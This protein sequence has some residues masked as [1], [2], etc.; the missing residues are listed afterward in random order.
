MTAMAQPRHQVSRAVAQLEATLDEVADASVWSMDPAETAHTLV[1][2]ERTEARLVE[3]KS[4]VAAH[5]DD[6]HVGQDVGAPSAAN[7]L[8]HETK[9]T[10]SAAHRTVRFGHDL[11]E[12][13]LTRG[14][15]ASG[16]VRAE[17]ARVIIRWVDKLPDTLDAR[18]RAKAE[19]HLLEQ[20]REHD[21]KGLNRLGKHLFEVVAPDEADAHEADILE[22]EEAAAAKA[23]YLTGHD[24]G[25]GRAHLRAT[26]PTYHWAALRK[27]LHALMAPK[28]QAATHGAGV[29]RRPTPEAMGRALC[30][31]IE[32]YPADKLPHT[33]GVNATMVV[34]LDLDVLLGRL[35]KA[36]ILDTGE[37][38][39]PAL[40]RR[41]AC[42]A[43]IIPVVL[44]GDSQP[45]DLGR[46][47]RLYTE[48]Q[49]VA[50]FV[51]DRGC[52]AEG[53]DR[54]TGLHAHHKH[55][56]TDGGRTDLADG[57]TLC[58]WHHARAHD[59]AYRTTYH[60]Q[61]HVTYHRRT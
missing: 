31:L 21:A 43:G 25:Q 54:T 37:K 47:R 36:G 46:R 45:L 38:I 3:L 33:G 40:A 44:D 28:H 51:R 29:E 32:R 18:I 24:D 35:E 19:R 7:W 49:R 10:R 50:M 26:L 34:L 42:E 30:E 11:E 41:L 57:I 12:H 58:P 55:R 15:L 20:A 9:T 17:Q 61:G 8:A 5:A 22:R 13:S 60:P 6:L 1:A 39:S 14:A 52:R 59:S 48:Y 56:W 16:D 2:L 4:R 27:M 23:C 53:C